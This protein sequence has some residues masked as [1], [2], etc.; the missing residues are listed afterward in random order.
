MTVGWIKKE[1]HINGFGCHVLC[2][3]GI[4]LLYKV[5]P[6]EFFPDV[7]NLGKYKWRQFLTVVILF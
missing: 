7:S 2:L 1:V 6:Y 3:L 5:I 4:N